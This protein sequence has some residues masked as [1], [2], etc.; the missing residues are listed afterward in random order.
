MAIAKATVSG[1]IRRMD[2]KYTPSGTAIC[3]FSIPVDKKWTDKASGDK[4]EHT[5][6]MNIFAMGKQ[7]EVLEKY[8]S[9][10]KGITVMGDIEV[11]EWESDQGRRSKT[12]IKMQSFDFPPV[13]KGEG[14]SSSQPT[15]SPKQTQ[16]AQ[17]SAPQNFD[18]FDDD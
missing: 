14:G 6:W 17:S 1:F 12:V 16:Q 4:R 18:D 10:G 15:Q 8:F 9:V 11:Q 3:E 7:A 2:T 5:S 13:A